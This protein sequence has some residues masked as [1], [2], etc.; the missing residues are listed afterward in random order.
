[1]S[2]VSYIGI[3]FGLA[4]VFFLF[5]AYALHWAHKNKQLENLEEG[6][7]SIFDEEEPEGEQTDFFPGQGP[8]KRSSDD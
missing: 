7:R 3:F 4:C 2:W 1:M 5:A 8:N 6:A